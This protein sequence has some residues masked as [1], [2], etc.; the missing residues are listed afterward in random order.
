[1]LTSTAAT[2]PSEKIRQQY[3][4]QKPQP[5][6]CHQQTAPSYRCSYGFESDWQDSP[7]AR[8]TGLPTR[9]SAKIA[10]P[11][12][13]N[14]SSR[15][16]PNGRQRLPGIRRVVFF[17]YPTPPSSIALYPGKSTPQAGTGLTRPGA[18]GFGVGF[19][20]FRVKKMEDETRSAAQSQRKCGTFGMWIAECGLR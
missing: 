11:D 6:Q 5:Q 20:P 2:M 14:I 15:N 17:F 16:S 18:N 1:M 10:R 13:W 19:L 7:A 4:S 9:T 8:P 3:P 12:P